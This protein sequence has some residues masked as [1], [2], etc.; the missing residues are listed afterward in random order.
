MTYT[1]TLEALAAAA[2]KAT[3]AENICNEKATAHAPFALLAMIDDG[4]SVEAWVTDACTIAEVKSKKG[5]KNTA[6]LREGGFNG[7]YNMAQ[8]LKW[9]EDNVAEFPAIE[10][11][12]YMFCKV[13]ATG[14]LRRD[15]LISKAIMLPAEARLADIDTVAEAYNVAT[16]GAKAEAEATVHAAAYWKAVNAPDTFAAFMKAAKEAAKVEKD[17]FAEAVKRMVAAIAE[18]ELEAIVSRQPELE[19]L[20]A[21]IKGAQERLAPV[22]VDVNVKQVA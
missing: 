18:M 5:K 3:K 14:D 6:A 4:K 11:L 9:I 16:V 8:S 17:A 2:S 13:D 21:A 19:T 15:Y 10:G 22:D 20:Y 12:A 7:L 1:T